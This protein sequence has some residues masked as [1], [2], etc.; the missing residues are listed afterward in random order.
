M[1]GVL[2][3]RG[4]MAEILDF[5]HFELSKFYISDISVKNQKFQNFDLSE[6]LSSIPS[7]GNPTFYV[8]STLGRKTQKISTSKFLQFSHFPPKFSATWKT[9]FEKFRHCER[10]HSPDECQQ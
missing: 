8:C 10:S 5:F 7:C 9:E 6:Q 4:L 1:S 2:K 3:D